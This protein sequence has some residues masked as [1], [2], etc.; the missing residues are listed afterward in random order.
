MSSQ[1][2]RNLLLVSICLGLLLP[3]CYPGGEKEKEKE[4]LDSET[5]LPDSG[6]S[7]DSEDTQDTVDTHETDTGPLPCVD[8]ASGTFPKGVVWLTFDGLSERLLSFDR[9]PLDETYRG[10]YGTYNLNTEEVWGANGF[11]LSAPATVV[12]AQAR[13]ENLGSGEEVAAVLQLLP[14][15]SS[16]GYAF[17]TWEP[18]GTY[19]R[20][21]SSADEREWVDYVFP[22]SVEITQPLHVFAGYHREEVTEENED[23]DPIFTEP[24]LLMEY[25]YN[26]VEPF[27]SGVKW[28]GIDRRVYYDG[29]ITPFYT[30]Q[31]RLAVILHDDIPAEDKPFQTDPALSAS[32]RV[33]WGDYDND[34]WDDLMTSGAT[35]YHN[36]GDGTFTNVTASAIPAGIS[37][38][39]GGVWGDYD[40]DGCLDY[41]GQGGSTGAGE[42]LLHSLCDGTFEDTTTVSGISDLQD[43]VDCEADGGSSYSPTEGAGWFDYDGDGFIDLYLAEYECWISSTEALYFKDRLFRNN[44]DGTF[45]DTSDEAVVGGLDTEL[46]AG[47]GVTPADYDLDGDTDLFVSNY[48]L[49]ANYFFLNN[50]DGTLQDIAAE[51]GTQGELTSGAYGHT[52][53][54]VFG[55]IDNDG[56]F[57]L[58][59]ANLAHPFYYD[60]SDKTM[61]L[62]NDGKGEFTDEGASRGIYYRETSSN[63]TLLDADND[64]DLDLFIT[65]VYVDRDS[66]Y[67]ENDGNGYFIL[68]NYES[69]LIIRN[70]WGGAASDF[71]NDGDMDLVAYGLF[72]N[73][74]DSTNSFLQVRAVGLE[75]NA[76]AIGAVIQVDTESRS[77]L[78]LVSGGS[79]TSS[80]DSF[81]QHFGLGEDSVVERV[82]VHFPYGETV[83]VEGVPANERLWV[84]SDGTWSLGLTP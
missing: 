75:G 43:L 56:D 22:E 61:I 23:G 82:T 34:G 19:T 5:G 54:S 76:S 17:D 46:L 14:D 81:T 63:P 62:M 52:I 73:D 11:K 29:F 60:F 48:R 8:N 24:E 65:N 80:Q 3:A 1:V 26:E 67:Y 30:W 28:P 35:L 20:C 78:R 38:P 49:N 77:Q 42:L 74:I 44:G 55:D 25:T 79:G 10:Y 12:G 15:F 59:S 13:W 33:A 84:Y 31:V 45:T 41:F 72:R 58:V 4:P 40:N 36:E 32:S 50:G 47:R 37:S 83:T 70:G 21:L 53:G 6:D 7:G 2:H 66:D 16:D 68:Q 69:G 57:D 64:G 27:Y 39:G 51:N 71:D 9:S 18:Y